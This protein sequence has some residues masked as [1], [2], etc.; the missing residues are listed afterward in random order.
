[1]PSSEPRQHLLQMFLEAIAAVNG[2]RAVVDALKAAPPVGPQALIAVGKA[3][4]A[5]AQGAQE[6]LGEQITDALIVTKH[7]HEQSL[8]WPIITASHPLPDETSLSA[9]EA[10]LSFIDALPETQEVLVLLSGG[11]SSLV[12]ALPEGVSLDE[13]QRLNRW[14]L[15]SGIDIVSGNEIRKQLSLIK[16]GRL[17]Q[18]LW[19]RKVRCLLIS[20]VPGDD[21]ASVASGPL[22]PSRPFVLPATAPSWLAELIAEAAQVNVQKPFDH[23]AIEIV[24]SIRQAMSAAAD[25]ARGLGYDVELHDD[26]LTGD[27][28]RAGPALAQVLERSVSGMVHVWGGETTVRLPDNP[29]RGGRNQSLALAAAIAIAGRDDEYFLAAGTDG[30]DGPGEDAGA[31]VDGDSV[32]RGLSSRINAANALAQ[33][34]A[35]TFLEATGDLIAIGPTGTNVMDLAIGMKY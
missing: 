21:P 17:A 25:A 13:L 10:L 8:P 11:G 26:L 6:Q 1:M 29:G 27:V 14:F 24:A 30:S 7:G 35:G 33:A 5:M 15:S 31:I 16:G 3:A 18:R 4:A 9:G 32:S 34:D 19:P 12:E 28:L 2:R 23:V 20:D 22:S